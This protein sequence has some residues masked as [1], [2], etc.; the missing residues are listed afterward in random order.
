MSPCPCLFR[1]QEE[2][3]LT[4]HS[5]ATTARVCHAGLW[6]GWSCRP[7][8]TSGVGRQGKVVEV[9]QNQRAVASSSGPTFSFP[10]LPLSVEVPTG[11]AQLRN[12]PTFPAHLSSLATEHCLP[13]SDGGDPESLFFLRHGDRVTTLQVIASAVTTA[14]LGVGDQP[15]CLTRCVHGL[16][17]VCGLLPQVYIF[18]VYSQ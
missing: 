1:P 13:R 3:H 14:S 2:G 12:L 9:F 15:W 10:A 7:A 17:S 4:C 5:K 8:D 16:P 18:N 11:S 6:L